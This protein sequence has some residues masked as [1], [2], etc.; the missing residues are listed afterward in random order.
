MITIKNAEAILK[1][2]E[3][4]KIVGLVHDKLKGIIEPGI[5][6]LELDRQAEKLILKL[7]AKPSFKGYGGFPAT[8][9]ASVDEQVIHG[10]PSK[11]K[12]REGE[13]VSIDVG[14]FYLGYHGDAAFTAAV[15]T[16]SEEKARLIEITERSFY[17]GFKMAKAGNRLGDISHSIEKVVLDAGYFVVKE[18]VG[19]GIGTE[20]HEDP[21]VP[22]YGPPGRG[23]LLEPGM[24]LAIEPMVNMGTE[25]IIIL[26]DGWTVITRD[27]KPSAHY[28][29]TI[30]ITDSEPVI[31]TKGEE[32]D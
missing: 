24:A 27:K 13:I 7:G 17:E 32:L 4:G 19:H 3:A 26:D 28:E 30:L 11:R 10:I 12:L 20:L 15:G 25:S 9:C 1:M 6:L 18:F 16:I 29:H 5:T 31:L 2:T 23:P 8:I 22:N 21:S 14:A